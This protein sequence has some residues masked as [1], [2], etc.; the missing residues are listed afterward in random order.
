MNSNKLLSIAIG[1]ACL[2]ARG[3]HAETPAALPQ[4]D[5]LA[6]VVVTAQRRSQNVQDV[7]ISIQVVS[8]DSLQR[9][10]ADNLGD[11]ANFVPGLVVSSDSPTQPH[12]QLR[13]IGA[14]DFG[15]GTDPAVGVYVDGV[16]ASR[17][18]ASLLA[19]NDIERIEVLDG[20][21]GTLFGRSS[22]AGA[23][24]IT[25]KKPTDE[26]EGSLDLRFGNYGKERLEAMF[27]APLGDGMALRVNFVDNR[28]TGFIKDAATGAD[29]DPEKDWASRVAFRWD[30][31]PDSRLTIAWN[32]DNLDQLARP[33][34]SLVA[35]PPAGS[36]STPLPPNPGFTGAGLL[37]P[38]NAPVFDDAVGN[39]ENRNL[40]D[41]VVNFEHHFGD[42]TFTS[43]T[44]WRQFK[45]FNREGETGTQS[46]ATY[47]DTANIEH[48][49]QWYQE[50]RL[51]AKN[52]LADWVLGASYSFE[53]AQQ[54]AQTNTYTDTVD[55]VLNNVGGVPG[56]L[57]GPTSAALA[58]FGIPVNLLGLPWQE[59][60]YDD[61]RFKSL[62][63]FGDVIWHLTDELN[64]TT[65]IRYS[66]DT[67]EYTWLAPARVSPALNTDLNTLNQLGVFS[68]IG[69]PES[70][71][72]FN[73]IFPEGGLQGVPFTDSGSWSDFSPRVVLDYR[74]NPNV[75]LYASVAKG[76]T[77]GG[78]DSVDINGRYAN[79]TVWNYEAGIKSTLPDAHV[80]LD[81]SV[82]HY[83]YNNKQALVLSNVS[84]STSVVPEYQVS[85]SNQEATGVDLDM[86]WQPVTPVTV[87]LS[88]RYIDSTYTKY[89]SAA[90]EEYDSFVPAIAAVNPNLAGQPTGEPLWSFA[91]TV[92]YVVPLDSRGSVDFFAGQ[93]YRGATRCNSEAQATFTCLPGAPFHLGQAQNQTDARIGW[94]ADKNRWGV[95][96]Y[97]TNLFNERYVTSIDTITASTIGTPYA[98]IN[99]PRRYGVDLHA[100]F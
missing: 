38:I 72:F 93:S 7:P 87:T 49:D 34:I 1:A 32:H 94:R 44:D 51:Q 4:A 61:G 100:A 77:P 68:A 21:Q 55:T 53:H 69:I 17:S 57:F 98:L 18:G 36:F 66:H 71:Y 83:N 26:Y 92:D 41:F 40:D 80:V 65:G 56:G 88:G 23:I 82:Y 84:G 2:A 60:M 70:T 59:T 76:F 16:Y 43:L 10:A 29:L 8:G 27:N 47:F 22:A 13:G 89:A 5:A 95:S 90:L 14:S 75:M 30:I 48:N 39:A 3:A 73:L 85:V 46:L 63:V 99:A 15:V 91:A 20:P 78:F 11:M 97:A 12:F 67:K 19:F 42:V 31:S 81:A 24:S 33:P 58:Q 86:R 28:A 52:S 50:F 74:M 64:L 54:A 62:G 6:E 37:N 35:V 79:E 25:T 96:F 45:T 9:L